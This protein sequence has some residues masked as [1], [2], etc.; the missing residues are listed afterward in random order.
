MTDT[1]TIVANPPS[2]PRTITLLT[3]DV[4][5]ALDVIRREFFIDAM[6]DFYYSEKDGGYNVV[7]H[8]GPE[9]PAK[10]KPE[11]AVETW[12]TDAVVAKLCWFA[13]GAGIRAVE[14]LDRTE[15][16]E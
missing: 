5:Q 11:K 12:Y 4:M 9:A 7:I 13:V 15:G 14:Y 16:G 6:T 2:E 1:A 8:A 10:P 3:N